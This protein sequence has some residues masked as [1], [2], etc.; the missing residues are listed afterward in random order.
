MFDG[1]ATECASAVLHLMAAFL[2]PPL[3]R[4]VVSQ[5]LPKLKIQTP[6]DKSVFYTLLWVVAT[7]VHHL[8]SCVHT[9]TRA[10][11]R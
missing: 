6:L 1:V 10:H 9:C 7:A 3:L 5:D 4:Y 8:V 2:A 11:A